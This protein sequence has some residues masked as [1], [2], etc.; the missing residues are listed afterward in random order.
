MTKS[1][2]MGMGTAHINTRI[3]YFGRRTVGKLRGRTGNK[4]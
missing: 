1:T 4:Q 2:G 3:N